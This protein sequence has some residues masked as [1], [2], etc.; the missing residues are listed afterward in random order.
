M[1]WIWLIK[2]IKIN[3]WED[4][5]IKEVA[6]CDLFSRL[7]RLF[8]GHEC[9]TPSMYKYSIVQWSWDFKFIRNLNDRE[10]EQ[11]AKMLGILQGV[12]LNNLKED[13][14][15]WNLD[16]SWCFSTKSYFLNLID[17]P[18]VPSFSPSYRIWKANVIECL[19]KLF[20]LS[21]LLYAMECSKL[22]FCI[23]VSFS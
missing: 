19:F 15:V 11:C 16:K 14:R 13:K 3:F 9:A 8:W 1:D 10:S 22:Q 5:W 17:N 6:L 18:D 20:L 4:C 23:P 21:F 2:L 7:Y 12:F